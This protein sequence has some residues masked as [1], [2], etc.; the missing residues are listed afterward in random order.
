LSSE[1][2]PA[3]TL[4]RPVARSRT[5]ML[6]TILSGVDPGSVETFTSSK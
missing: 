6:M 1:L 2:Y 3:P 4:N 5:S